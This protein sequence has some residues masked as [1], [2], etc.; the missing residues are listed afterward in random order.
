[1]CVILIVP[2]ILLGTAH[3]SP[4]TGGWASLHSPEAVLQL[5]PCAVVERWRLCEKGLTLF[6]TPFI[7]TSTQARH[8]VQAAEPGQQFEGLV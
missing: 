4:L 2:H 1:M 5:R 8:H 7:Q 6:K 3:P